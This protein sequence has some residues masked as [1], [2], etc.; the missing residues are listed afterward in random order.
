MMYRKSRTQGF[1]VATLSL[2]LTGCLALI[3]CAVSETPE[4]DGAR[5]TRL[6]AAEVRATF[7][8]T[9]WKGSSS[10]FFFRPNGTYVYTSEKTTTE[11]GPW[12]YRINDD[13]S[14]AGASSTYTFYKIGPGY[15][16]HNSDTDAFYRAIPDVSEGARPGAGRAQL[17]T[18]LGTQL[19]CSAE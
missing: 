14:I 3:G 12:R 8:G 6:T 4:P 17:E 16:Y 1:A 15:R 2:A 11:W 5:G 18:C 10:V 9:P 13:G 19:F 7:I